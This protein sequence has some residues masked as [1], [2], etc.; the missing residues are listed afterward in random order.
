MT[1]TQA[2]ARPGRPRPAGPGRGLLRGR[3]RRRRPAHRRRPGRGG[4]RPGG[5]AEE[6]R[7]SRSVK[8]G[9]RVKV[10]E[11]TAVLRLDRDRELELRTGTNVVLEEVDGRRAGAWPSPC[12]SRT[13]C[14]CRP[15]RA[16]ASRCPPRAPTSSSAAAAQD[17]AG[18]G[19]GRVLLRRATSSCARATS[20][21]PSPPCGRSR[22]TPTAGPS[23]APSPLSYDADDPWDR[24]FLSDAIELGN[25]LEARSKGFSAQLGADRRPHRRVPPRAAARPRRPARLRPTALRP[26]PP[27]GRVAGRRR[28]RPGGHPG[29][30][31]PSGGPASSASATRAPSGAW[32]PS[33]RA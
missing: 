29:H 23:P 32:S 12:S 19:A 4:R 2:P 8:F 20:R 5:K 31:S 16:P 22:S 7:G 9:E 13:T 11:G 27:A 6:E 1:A 17:L 30:A 3:R 21:P 24:R 28:H 25:E 10:L 33:T 14:W 15:R 26:P 18:A